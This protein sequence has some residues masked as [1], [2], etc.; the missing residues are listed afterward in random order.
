VSALPEPATPRRVEEILDAAAAVFHQRGYQGGT[1]EE[2]GARL[3]ITRA[4]LYYYFRSKQDLLRALLTRA[5]RAGLAELETA[6]ASSEDPQERL[7]ACMVSLLELIGRERELFTIYFQE[8]EAVMRAAGDDAR[9]IEEAYVRRFTEVV[10]DALA[11][12][13]LHTVDAAIVA[14]GILGMCNWTYRWLRPNAPLAP[15]DVAVQ[16]AEAFGLAPVSKP[17]TKERRSPNER[18]QGRHRQR[19]AGLAGRRR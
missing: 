10:G 13:E 17:R 19:H 18:S 8:N 12:R 16:W 6:I 7:V 14:R 5:M 9:R 1:L 4:A 11:A 3:N 2:V 15:A